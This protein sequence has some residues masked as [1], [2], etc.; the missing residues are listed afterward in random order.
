MIFLIMGISIFG[1]WWW[2]VYLPGQATTVDEKP[3]NQIDNSTVD[4][5]YYPRPN[6]PTHLYAINNNACKE[7]EIVTIMTL[8]GVLAKTSP[9]IYITDNNGYYSQWANLIRSEGIPITNITD[10]WWLINNLA[11]GNVSG[12]ILWKADSDPTVHVGSKDPFTSFDTVTYDHQNESYCVAVS[13]CGIMNAIA[14]EVNDEAKAQAAG[15]TKKFDACDKNMDWLFTSEY[16]AQLRHDMIFE[17]EY[18]SERRWCLIDYPVF[19]GAPVWH[20]ATHEKRAEYLKYFEADSPSFGW[21]AVG[22]TDEAGLNLQVTSAGGFFMPSDWAR[23]ISTLASI[24]VS[25]EQ[26][27]LPAL[28]EE[29]NVHYVSIIMSDGDNLQWA[30]GDYD[31]NK[32]FSNP[33]RGEFAMGWMIPPAMADLCPLLLRYYYQKASTLDRFVAGNSGHGLI[34]NAKS[35]WHAIHVNRSGP[36]LERAD[37]DV[38]VIQDFGW[39]RETF[40]PTCALP[41][42]TGVIYNDYRQYAL[43]SGKAMWVHDKPC[44]SFTYNFWLGFDSAS[45]MASSI[46]TASK[47]INSP[48]AYSLIVVHA[49]SHQMDDVAEFVG[50]LGKDVRVVDPET[51]IQLYSRNVVHIDSYAISF[52]HFI[53]LFGQYIGIVVAIGVG[54]FVIKKGI[55]IRKSKKLDLNSKNKPENPDSTLK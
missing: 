14:V 45:G 22:P 24:Q 10:P 38:V 12:Y 36:I 50:M 48:Y 54:V 30:M 15:L 37:I 19:C 4:C 23:D 35:P 26:K 42:V 28:P 16:W 47:N 31:S 49:W 43:Q 8:Q 53:S 33:H 18:H 5:N 6:R 21:G 32:F 51:F 20:A 44:I 41:G 7:E 2:D 39:Q 11:P 17:V 3:L 1:W 46:N 13:L 40:E 29:K 25:C 27:P 9:Q 55:K 52:V 34:Y